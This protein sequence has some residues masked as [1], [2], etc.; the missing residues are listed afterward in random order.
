M[1]SGVSVAWRVIA[2]RENWFRK[3]FVC[4]ISKIHLC[5]WKKIALNSLFECGKMLRRI[6][7]SY[8][9][10][11]QWVEIL[12]NLS[13][14]QS[15]WLAT[16]IQCAEMWSASRQLWDKVIDSQGSKC[17]RSTIKSVGDPVTVWACLTFSALCRSAQGD[18][19]LPNMSSMANSNMWICSC[20]SYVNNRKGENRNDFCF[21][22][23]DRRLMQQTWSV[24]WEVR[25]CNPDFLFVS[26]QC[27]SLKQLRTGC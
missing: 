20:W 1:G 4:Q 19:C 17:R 2:C 23:V 5:A 3:L 21:Q 18:L 7:H 11:H 22:L 8:K 12:M 10:C 27:Q 16:N 13:L 26:S 25:F 24:Q 14:Q 6:S 15:L 9:L